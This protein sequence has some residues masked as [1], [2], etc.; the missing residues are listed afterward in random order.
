MASA[1]AGER[2]GPAE[3]G[4]RAVR[5][6]TSAARRLGLRPGEPRVLHDVFNVLV[7]LDPEPVVVRVPSLTFAT[8]AEQA[9]RQRRELD[10]VRWLAGQGAPVVRPSPL[11]PPEPVESE[12]RSLTFWEYVEERDP[13]R[14]VPAEEWETR[15]A[16]QTG[17]TAPLHALLARYPGPLPT[18]SPL[19]P[20]ARAA[21]DE[22]ARRP[23]DLT[24]DDLDRAERE[25]AALE[26]L[27]PE[28]PVRFPGTRPQ[29]LHGDAPAY[30]VLRTAGGHLF[31][32]F[33]DVT[34]G[35]VEWDLAG[36]GPRGVEAYLRAGGTPV[37]S[38]LLDTMERARLFQAVAA[39]A[40]AP[41]MPEL[42]GLLEPLVRQWRDRPP[43]G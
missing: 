34:R 38:R 32:D 3:R 20:G 43:L 17:W 41:L 35:P 31:A 12:G 30:N 23:G 24:P 14:D 8:A 13:V 2:P 28:L 18:L 27:L 19:V 22:L 4:E 6:A 33:E 16:E 25:Y 11:V 10:V 26:A 1:T 42:A 7:H 37:D 40:Y 5:A 9:E 21:L 15:F 29:P 39:L 36:C